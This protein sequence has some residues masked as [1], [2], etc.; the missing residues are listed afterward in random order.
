[1]ANPRGHPETLKS[2]NTLDKKTHAAMSS[3]GGKNSGAK[4]REMKKWKDLAKEIMAMPLQKG[5]VKDKITSLAEAKG[6]NIDTQTAVILAQVV[7]A[8]KGDTKA[9][10]FLYSLSNEEVEQIT[11]TPIVVPDDTDK[12]IPFFDSVSGDIKRHGHTH[13]WF[14]GGRGS[15]KS[16]FISMKIP[17]LI[18]GNP[19]VN[20]VILRKVANTLKNSVY[21]Q[22]E[23]ALEQLELLQ[24]FEFKK[25][26]LEIIY[27][28]TGQK[29]LFLGADDRS[30]IK[31]L[32]MPF[33]YVGCVWYEELDQFSGMDE[34]RS[35]NQSLLRGGDKYWCFYSFNPPKSRDNWVNVEQLTDYPDR[36]ISHS[37]YTMVPSDWLGDQFIIEAE[38]L[39]EQ[40]P[41]LYEHEYM[42]IATGTGGDV[43]ANVEEM[44]ITDEMIENFDN[45]YH[46]I[47]FGFAQDPFV[48]TKLHYDI[49]HDCIYIYDEVYSTRLKN[50][51]AY[52][53]IK[54]KVGTSVVWADSAE[55]K[56]IAELADMGLRIYGVKKGP[57]SREFS[58]K[59]LSD[60]FKIY[61]D[62]N[63]CPNAYREFTMYEYDQDKHGNF[64]SAYPKRNDHTIDAV[65]YS[66]R[67]E[68]D[69]NKFSW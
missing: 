56:S 50:S 53:K 24:E 23:W 21:A 3:K 69:A 60:R 25:S 26:P 40:R 48:Y 27:K 39:K 42:G 13:Y 20:V 54:D 31:S 6:Q 67:S 32:K 68:M 45:N 16:S 43:F 37:N 59:W 41:D 10:E 51:M 4:R 47:D 64:I 33:G 62:K 5:K 63:R 34:I 8:T 61:I 11:E 12:I 44:T 65:R 36:L 7:K 29:I 49:K 2:T 18:I 30:K 28:R 58:I 17:Q 15:T 22:I 19:H 38:K 1:M 52:E 14:K 66:L 46:G 57:D 9:A 55:P 35:I